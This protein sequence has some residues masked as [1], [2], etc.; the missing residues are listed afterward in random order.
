MH[1]V[2]PDTDLIAIVLPLASLVKERSNA[3]S[4]YESYQAHV[5]GDAC[6]IKPRQRFL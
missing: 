3:R 2:V 5:T 4:S 1:R 6:F